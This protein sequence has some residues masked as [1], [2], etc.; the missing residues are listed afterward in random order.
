MEF[1]K[2][3]DVVVEQDPT[4]S[5]PSHKIMNYFKLI[6]KILAVFIL[7]CWTSTSNYLN[8]LNINTDAMYP[9]GK[10]VERSEQHVLRKM[11]LSRLKN[12]GL[13]LAMNDVKT[14]P[15]A[16]MF[17]PGGIDMSKETEIKEKVGMAWWYERTQ[18]S[19]YQVGG[20]ILHNVFNFFKGW[21]QV[22]DEEKGKPKSL[23]LKFF[24][25]FKWV[26]FGLLSNMCFAMLFGVV[27]FL[28]WIP[29][30]LGGLTAF[31][32]LTY[33]TASPLLKLVYKGFLLFWTFMWMC[34]AG[35]VIFFPVIYGCFH[36]LYLAFFKQL[37]DNLATFVDLFMKRI[38]QLMYIYITVAFII[39]IASKDLPDETKITVAVVFGASLA[40]A[41]YKY[42]TS[43]PESISKSVESISKIVEKNV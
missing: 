17:N 8:S 37:E 20:L 36:L 11:G 18:Q 16:T 14:N 4:E 27:I 21:I 12:F 24:S 39:A 13:P 42:Q 1:T 32:P 30:F 3:S 19:S 15:Y 28:F 22:S 23:L 33:Y 7:F 29:G 38:G 41:A 9:I 26:I 34:I 40:Y 35:W 5:I 2:L 31:M 10:T 6:L 25:F 43:T